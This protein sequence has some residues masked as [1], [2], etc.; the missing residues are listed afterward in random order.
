MNSKI[1]AIKE[2]I[3]F[4]QHNWIG[5][6]GVWQGD[7]IDFVGAVIESNVTHIDVREL[8]SAANNGEPIPVEGL[9]G[10]IKNN[11]IQTVWVTKCM[12]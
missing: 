2:A 1:D 12:E 9:G 3:N 4:I 10:I 7:I 8:I 11:K 5:R 6:T